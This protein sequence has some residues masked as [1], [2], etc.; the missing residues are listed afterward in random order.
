[1]PDDG[2]SS[3]SP[4]TYVKQNPVRFITA[5]SLFDGHDAAINIMRRILQSMG[6][7]VIHLGHNRSVEDVV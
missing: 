7:E 3:K 2:L 6:V 1:M 4:P 5:A